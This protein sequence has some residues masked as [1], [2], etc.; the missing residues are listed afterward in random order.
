[1]TMKK[2]MLHQRYMREISIAIFLTVNRV[3]YIF[4]LSQPKVK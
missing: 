4:M 1:M 3:R 2:N